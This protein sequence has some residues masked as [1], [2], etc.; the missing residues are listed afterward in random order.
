MP[1]KYFFTINLLLKSDNNIKNAIDSIT[2]DERFFRE[3]VQLILID[4][5][6]SPEI[7]EICA[8]FNAKYPE[9]IVFLDAVGMNPASCYNHAMH[10]AVG[11]YVSFIDN[12][13]YYEKGTLRH[14]KDILRNERIPA[15]CMECVTV[16]PSGM[17]SVYAADIDDGVVRLHETPEKLILH[18]GCWFFLNSAARKLRFDPD[19]R[20]HSEQKYIIDAMCLT[21]SYV[22]SSECTFYTSTPSELDGSRYAAQYST[23]FYIRSVK[24]F[25]IP[26]LKNY[27]GSY[28]AQSAMMYL[29]G[30]KLAL[31]AGDRY[32]GIITG[33]RLSEFLSLCSEAF[34]YIDDSVILNR[35]ILERC[36]LDA[37]YGYCF[38]K[39]KY[40]NPKLLPETDI[41]PPKKAVTFR[42]RT[43]PN[44]M[45][46]ISLSGEFAAHTGD[47]LVMRSADIR[48]NVRT[49]NFGDGGM[50][51]DA[52]LIGASQ[53][54]G[55]DHSVYAVYNGE[56]TAVIDS[57]VCTDRTI[58]G[59][60]L[61]R[62]Y[63]F[64]IFVSFSGGKSLDA[65]CFYFKTGR[66]S[67]RLPMTF[68]GIH[69]RLSERIHGTCVIYGDRAVTYDQKSKTLAVRR[70]TDSLSALS[71]AK[72]L[73]EAT[74]TEGLSGRLYYQRLRHTAKSLKNSEDIRRIIVFYDEQGINSGGNLLFRYFTRHASNKTICYFVTE[75]GSPEQLLLNDAGYENVLEKGSV[76][77][78]AMAL[79]ADMIIASDNDSYGG[80]GFNEA[81]RLYLRDLASAQII[82]VK[83]RFLSTPHPGL[84]N[85]LMDNIRKVYVASADEKTALS[86]PSLDYDEEMIHTVGNPLLD[87]LSDKREKLILISPGERRIF[88]IYDHSGTHRFT[89]SIFCRE[90]CAL[91]NDPKLI[92][93]CREKGYKIALMMPAGASK[94]ETTF[95]QNDVISVYSY[96]E[97]NIRH[98]VSHAMVLVTDYSDLQYQFAYLGK[99]VYYYYPTGLPSTSEPEGE[100]ISRRGFGPV[101]FDNVKLIEALSSGM[102][103]MFADEE[104]YSDRRKKFFGHSDREN[105]ARICEDM[106]VM[107]KN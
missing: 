94:Y 91:L 4:P 50:Y 52:E 93:S 26:M 45:E 88:S 3:N 65:L 22:Y 35:R 98:L 90:Y 69:S 61:F 43:S 14:A 27:A 64:R 97:Q 89:E 75:K 33:S 30:V 73:S 68:E 55:G 63:A 28:L 84:D 13:C 39:M 49:I 77:A 7:T 67:V 19:I 53:L 8:Q 34:S 1:M 47:V 41:V 42:Y 79:A 32:K 10:F 18:D 76:R 100:G 96:K 36:G 80:I 23:D 60:V 5:V 85:R 81:D 74:K 70:A 16:D 25:I 83:D 104:K 38:L 9:N 40:N 20:F 95:P 21:Y 58:F 6:G 29:L 59:R 51:I 44:R 78:K 106:E 82:S 2:G 103:K 46:E 62:R 105:C 101:F 71:E 37:E 48:A 54:T 15:F 12:L 86:D 17:D 99:S 31:N 87:A 107:D 24:E 56:K 72:I 92:S 57:Q 102:R 11:S 66:L